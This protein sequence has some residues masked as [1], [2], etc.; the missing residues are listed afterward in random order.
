MFFT[1]QQ[2]CPHDGNESAELEECSHVSDEAL[3]NR[4]ARKNISLSLEDF[5]SLLQLNHDGMIACHDGSR[6][7]IFP[8]G[9][10]PMSGV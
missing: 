6:I 8:H 7:D 2:S 10:L 5:S 1:E 9:R 4:R 3:S